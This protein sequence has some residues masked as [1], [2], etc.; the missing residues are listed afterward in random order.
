MDLSL[1]H[2]TLLE[3]EI[4]GTLQNTTFTTSS[5]TVNVTVL[6]LELDF[7]SQRLFGASL[8]SGTSVSW[9]RF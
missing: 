4:N 2:K 3:S 5:T 6:Q 1:D 7:H 8:T 9:D